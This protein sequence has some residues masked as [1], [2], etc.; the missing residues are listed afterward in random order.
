MNLN[1]EHE[2]M[3]KDLR[4]CKGNIQP[5]SPYGLPTLEHLNEEYC[6]PVSEIPLSQS[7]KDRF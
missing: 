4:A 6:L 1:K 7:V 3:E 5:P 2:N